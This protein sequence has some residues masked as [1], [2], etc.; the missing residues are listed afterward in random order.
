M[1]GLDSREIER[2]AE[3]PDAPHQLPALVRRL[4]LATVPT[5]SLIDMPSGSSVWNS[6]WDGLL[7]IESGNPWAPP[8]KS[9]WEF[10]AGNDPQSK[11]NENYRKRTSDPLGVDPE[12]STFVFVSPRG[13]AGKKDWIENRRSE[14]KWAD[15]RAYDA[16]D[17]ATWLEQAPGIA[18]WFARLTGR[19][20]ESGFVCLNDWWDNWA[21]GTQPRILPELV[22]AG[23]SE[24]SNA[25][26]NWFASPPSGFYVKGD[27]RDEAIAFL[28]ANALDSS[29]NMGTAFL[30][31][32]VVVEN[33]NAWR[34]L[35]QG[36]NPMILIRNFVEDVSSQVAIANGHHVVAPLDS[37]QEPRGAGHE[38]PRLGR[39]E[40]IEALTSMGMSEPQARALSRKAARRLPVMRRLLLEEAGT[41]PPAWAYPNTSH[42]LTALVPIGQWSEEN[43]A[44]KEVVARLTGKSYEEAERELIPLLNVADSPLTKIGPK[45]RYVSHEEAWHLLAPYL[46]SSDAERFEEIA[47][48]I[49]SQKSPAFDLPVEERFMPGIKGK[50]LPHSDTLIHG[51]ARGLALIGTQSER[52]MN[53]ANASYI[54]SR[55]VSRVLGEGSDWRSWATHSAYLS[56]LA[57]A[58]PEQF[59]DAVEGTLDSNP[60]SF[61][62]LFSQDRN[63]DVLFN[64][65]P[66]AGLLWGLECLAWSEDYFSRAALLL[67]R[68]AELDPGGRYSNRPAESVANLFHWQLRFS[69]ASDGQ[70]IDALELIL[71]NAP[72]VGWMV[73]VKN[74]SYDHSPHR[75][76]LDKTSWRPWGQE[77]YSQATQDELAIFVGKLCDLL[78]ANLGPVER[79]EDLMEILPSLPL[80]TRR[81]ALRRL[82]QEAEEL[83]YDHRATSLRKRIKLTLNRHRSFPDTGW[84]V[85]PEDVDALDAIYRNLEPSDPVLAHAWLFESEWIDLPEGECRDYEKQTARVL[86]AQ[87][88]AVKDIFKSDGIDGISS[89]IGLADA[90]HTVGRAV[91]AS[92]D[93][94]EA[95]T[96]ALDC[97]RSEHQKRKEF[98][99]WFFNT[100]CRQSGLG[101]LDVSLEAI[102]SG[103]GCDPA[104]VAAIYSSASSADLKGCLQRLELESQSVQ[105]AYWKSFHWFNLARGNADNQVFATVVQRL[106]DSGRSLSALELMWS[107]SVS[108]E[109]VI[110]TLK[111]IPIDWSNGTD[112]VNSA[113]GYRCADI[114]KRLD[115]SANVSDEV[116][117]RL[118]IPLSEVIREYRPDLAL[119]RVVLRSP[120]VFADLITLVFKRADG[121]DDP[122]LDNQVSP[123][124]FSL[125]YRILSEL[126]G[127][128]GMADDGTIDSETLTAWVSEARR[129]CTERDRRD[130]GDQK[131][132]AVLANAPV[133]DDGV[134][135]CEPVRDLLD[136]LPEREHIGIGFHTGRYNQRGVTS[137]GVYD[138]G[139]QERKLAE[140]YRSDA[141]MMASRW[142][143]TAKLLREIADGYDAEAHDMDSRAKWTDEAEF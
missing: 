66:Q 53:V 57:E 126:R 113:L 16:D 100:H 107:R 120:N 9:A 129:L 5:P 79:W 20:P 95:F 91:A 143:F 38:L 46:A 52:M 48:E 90:P 1:I 87:N 115:A 137:R 131:I 73:L 75:N 62:T 39:D 36:D 132:G 55:V 99:M 24:P 21:S 47:S 27:T 141:S 135:P 138:G 128:P 56:T 49:L 123:E 31:K 45:W 42:T 51:I 3:M 34:V 109:L 17:L 50:A 37:S 26:R 11:A 64:S 15:V 82:R 94:D 74:L 86:A 139:A 41:P 134:W 4:I 97:V 84:A 122:D 7:E 80:D 43:E 140:G 28:V 110:R 117:A 89:L 13:W 69:E 114:F 111:Q 124:R 133:G 65:A 112:I 23:R 92:I 35:E 102:K 93:F 125:L 14:G 60:D 72:D 130:I 68:L 105:E 85:P 30:T 63:G 106:L 101:I 136:A 40:T 119:Y 61:I 81:V 2:W 104:V 116:I 121:A 8:G 25:I 108:D 78:L 103:E 67:A 19:F 29:Y 98:A 118:E 88:K 33:V 54:P 142:P 59:L 18:Q 44:D 83:K 22:L 32:A 76:L 127:L 58:A 77:G 70:R 10:S 6:G 96:L 12:S 71:K